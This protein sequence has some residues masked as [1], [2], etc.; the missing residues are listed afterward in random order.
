[1]HKAKIPISV[2]NAA[3]VRDAAKAQ[4]QRAKND[5]IDARMLTVYG[6]RFQP[7]PT[8]PLSQVQQQLTSLSV[9]LKQLILAQSSL[10]TI[11]EHQKSPF[12]QKQHQK[13][14]DYHKSQI[15]KT[16]KQ[17]KKLMEGHQELTRRFECLDAIEGVGFRTAVAVLAHM[18][19]LGQMNRGQAAALAG[20]A[21]WTRDSGT[22][23]GK[24]CI[25]GGRSQVRHA[26]YMS[27]LSAARCNPILKEVYQRLRTAGKPVKVALTALMRKLIGYMNAQ[28]KALANP[29]RSTNPQMAA[30]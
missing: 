8:A 19:E 18:P 9:W 28:L 2:V 10:K 15:K 13:L 29:P 1:M 16:E 25:G 20:L 5:R 14:L 26:L 22:M 12:V 11:A 23:K 24:R 21:P 6:R 30:V 7:Q 3:Q 17:I 4:G 27:A